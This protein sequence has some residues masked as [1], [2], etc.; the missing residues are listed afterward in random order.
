MA[1]GHLASETGV[2][3]A[4]LL[5]RAVHR[6]KP[7]SQE[8]LLERVFT[9][10]F[11]GL[12]YPQIWEDPVVDM[13]A[14]ALGSDHHVIAIASGGCN[15]LSYL[16][17]S[18]R[19]ITAV[20]V[21]RAH[22][23][24]TKLKIAGACWLPG[25]AEFYRFFGEADEKENLAVYRRHLAPRLDATTRLYWERRGWQGRK[26]ISH[27]R[28]NI[29]KR[30]LLGRFIGMS[31]VV[32]RA[33]GVDPK[34]VLA[35]RSPREQRM[36]FEQKIAPLFDKKFIRWVTN[37]KSSLFGLGIPPAQYDALVSDAPSMADI[38]KERLERLACDFPLRDN[39]F[40][41][42]AFAR[43]YAPG[44]SGPLPPYLCKHNFEQIRQSAARINVVHASLTDT[45]RKM[46]AGSVDR[47]V[48]LDAQDWMT[49]TQLNDLWHEITRT[50]GPRARVIFRTA[51][52][53]SILPGRVAA[54]LLSRWRYEE[55]ASR[56]LGA[57]DRSSVYGG[58]HLYI[59]RDLH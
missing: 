31:H 7:V 40:A 54:D 25:W 23:A 53:E 43:S 35:A 55:M 49:D 12:V 39:Y 26:R 8:G 22:V 51:G 6:S 9:L 17:A 21:N 58:F 50:A 46:E 33:Y 11:R 2:G 42:Q 19:G 36:F 37:R 24:L 1:F 3:S 38:L 30:G 47:Y 41:W 10:A 18:P 15:V 34:A 45:L 44:A 57:R 32:A 14:M 52:Y 4:R 28:R 56:D 48:L 20:D 13:E 29:Y 5:K 59:L 16:T 27:F